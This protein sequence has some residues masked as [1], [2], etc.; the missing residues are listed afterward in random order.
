MKKNVLFLILNAVLFF[1]AAHATFDPRM[2]RDILLD[3][4]TTL[5][6]CCDEIAI[7]YAGTFTVLSQLES[8][9][10]SSI[11]V[12]T[13][14]TQANVGTTGYVIT[15]SGL[16]R[17]AGNIL[18]S[19]SGPASALTINADDVVLDLA[20]YT[21]SQGNATLNV[22]GVTIGSNHTNVVVKNGIID[23]MSDNGILVTSGASV[24]ALDTISIQNCGT[25]GIFCQGTIGSPV[26]G[27]MI[28]DVELIGNPIGIQGS[29]LERAFIT[30][31]SILNSVQIGIEL[32]SS[33]SNSVDVCLVDGV[34]AASGSAYG[35]FL[36]NGA[37]NRVQNSTIRNIQ[38]ADVAL[39]QEA[40]GIYLGINENDAIIRNNIIKNCRTATNAQPYGIE[41]GYTFT[42]VYP[43]VSKNVG[44][45]LNSCLWDPNGHFLA[46]DK[47]GSSISS[48]LMFEYKNG[49][50]FN[51]QTTAG[52]FVNM[53]WSPD[54]SYYLNTDEGDTQRI[55]ENDQGLLSEVVQFPG[56]FTA[57]RVVSWSPNGRF[58]ATISAGGT[59]NLEVW[60][61]SGTTVQVVA[62]QPTNTIFG[63]DWSPDGQYLAVNQSN[64]V[65]NTLNIYQ[66]TGSSL[67]GKASYVQAVGSLIVRWNPNGQFIA[68]AGGTNTLEIYKFNGSSLSLISNQTVA[69][70][71]G[72][73]DWAP[74]GKWIAY[75]DTTN[76]LGIYAF[77][78]TSLSNFRSASIVSG[79]LSQ[80]L[81]WSPLGTLIAAGTNANSITLFSAFHFAH[82]NYIADNQITA[83]TGAPLLAG[84]PGFSS[85]RG[86]AASSQDN[87]IFNNIVFTADIGSIFADNIFIKYRANS[88]PVPSLLSNRIFPPL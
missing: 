69:G 15:Q 71:I 18:F 33:F 1:S 45:S 7:N 41:M 72:G 56:F 74:D 77:D 87:L 17:L 55:Y 35:I 23:S 30:D 58:I 21:I 52:G 22:E 25:S 49:N 40:V 64:G 68:R 32:L 75:T 46:I 80:G 84:Q 62:S 78:G 36:N 86:L 88:L 8:K 5:T 63:L 48:V 26:T 44:F 38:T 67:V 28:T 61:F 83:V 53:A 59:N 29:F 4:D 16:Y 34:Q 54:G 82:G 43:L 24:V 13:L 27:Q 60:K 37:H 19:P 9:F 51:A 6:A 79:G 20:C 85:G 57:Q 11:C 76:V 12:S 47:N 39:T 81:S 50:L 73:L 14:I 65:G 70:T 42:A 31:C 3:I 2:T 66:F 10:A